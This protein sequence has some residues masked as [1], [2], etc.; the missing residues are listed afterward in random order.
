MGWW[1][2]GNFD[3]CYLSDLY[4]T[5]L[6]K[7]QTICS[8]F[9]TDKITIKTLDSSTWHTS[10]FMIW[11]VLSCPSL[12]ASNHTTC[13]VPKH[14]ERTLRSS[15]DVCT[16]SRNNFFKTK[17]NLLSSIKLPWQDF[18]DLVIQQIFFKCL[19]CARHCLKYWGS[20]RGKKM[21]NTPAL[22]KFAW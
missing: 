18:H 21:T 9:F 14:S 20:N 1:G 3:K 4:F 17:L 2:L 16:S 19:P 12:P 10:S 7:T 22:G 11:P 6:S 13:L 8:K 5:G 15:W